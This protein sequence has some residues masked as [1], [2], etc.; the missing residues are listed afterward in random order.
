MTERFQDGV[1]TLLNVV[2]DLNEVSVHDLH[3]NI[4]CSCN[5]KGNNIVKG[6]GGMNV[7]KRYTN[8]RRIYCACQLTDFGNDC[9]IILLVN[10]YPYQKTVFI[11][12]TKY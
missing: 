6:E 1:Q 5:G 11:T 2:T 3:A 8:S 7:S 12:D 10:S 9:R 4:M